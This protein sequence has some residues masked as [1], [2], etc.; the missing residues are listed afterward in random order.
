[1]W[2]ENDFV[3]GLD[4]FLLKLTLI[5]CTDIMYTQEHQSNYKYWDRFAQKQIIE[6]CTLNPH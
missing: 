1:M 4:Y 3:G 6:L 2:K 5:Y